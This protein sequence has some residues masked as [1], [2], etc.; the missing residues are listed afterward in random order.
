MSLQSHVDGLRCSWRGVQ[1]WDGKD[2]QRRL[3]VVTAATTEALQN[4][5]FVIVALGYHLH[6][7][8][9]EVQGKQMYV[10]ALHTQSNSVDRSL[11]A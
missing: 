4:M 6:D 2:C 9:D 8:D 7:G 1:I 10:V 5:S 3:A 11:D